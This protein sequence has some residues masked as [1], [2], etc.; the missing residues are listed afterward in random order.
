[1]RFVHRHGTKPTPPEMPG[2]LLPRMN[3]A[4]VADAQAKT[5]AETHP[6][7]MGSGSNGR[8]WAREP[9]PRPPRPPPGDAGLKAL[10]GRHSILVYEKRSRARIAPLRDMMRNA[11]NHHAR[12]TSR[13]RGARPAPAMCQSSTVSP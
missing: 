9:K 10:R 5:P 1:M 11:G 12:K 2:L 13:A 6:N 8:D 7:R 3:A 4:G